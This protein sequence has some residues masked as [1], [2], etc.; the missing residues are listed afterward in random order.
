MSLQN[1][2]AIFLSTATLT[3]CS[4]VDTLPGAEHIILANHDSG[5]EKIG[6]TTVSVI[7][8]VLYVDRS[9]DTIAEELQILAQNSA[10]KMGGNAIWP[11][12]EVL[13][14]E[15]SYHIFRCPK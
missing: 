4:F 3:A 1:I 10:A 7:H 12:S 15:Q 2:L 6:Q 14:G 5:C 9:E 11:S 8:E 13:N